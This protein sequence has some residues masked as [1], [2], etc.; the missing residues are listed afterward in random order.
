MF[1]KLMLLVLVCFVARLGWVLD[2]PGGLVFG[3]FLLRSGFYR[4]LLSLNILVK[5]TINCFLGNKQKLPKSPPWFFS[6]R[7]SIAFWLMS[8]WT[9]N[10]IT[11]YVI[12]GLKILF[13]C[14]ASPILQTWRKAR[15]IPVH[16]ERSANTL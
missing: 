8:V 11:M 16:L 3:I 6:S 4:I 10:V 13:K 9:C 5:M 12:K 15:I 14:N 1:N 2:G 7:A